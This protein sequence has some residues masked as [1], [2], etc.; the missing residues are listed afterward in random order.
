MSFPSFSSPSQNARNWYKG[1][2]S[3][4]WWWQQQRGRE[5]QVENHE[6]FSKRQAMLWMGEL[7]FSLPQVLKS[8]VTLLP[9]LFQLESRILMQYDGRSHLCCFQWI[10]LLYLC[11]KSP[12]KIITGKGGTEG[13]KCIL[14]LP[15]LIC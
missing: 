15:C 5:K 6:G 12:I 3:K 13:A 7:I 2:G 8:L 4:Y 9:I 10:I 11:A 1:R 14:G